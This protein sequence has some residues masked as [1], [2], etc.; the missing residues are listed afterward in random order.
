MSVSVILPAVQDGLCMQE[1]R[2]RLA[3]GRAGCV[4]DAARCTTV[5]DPAAG[6][7]RALRSACM[8]CTAFG[9]RFASVTSFT[10][11]CRLLC[12]H[13]AHVLKYESSLPL[14]IGPTCYK[15][16]AAIVH[17]TQSM[18]MHFFYRSY[19]TKRSGQVPEP[20]P[21]AGLLPSASAVAPAGRGALES[22]LAPP[23]EAAPPWPRP[24]ALPPPVALPLAV[25]VL[26][27]YA[28]LLP[29]PP[30]AAPSAVP[31]PAIAL[32]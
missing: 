22:V 3:V 8:P 17:K 24:P 1:G 21:A 2:A 23:P 32:S 27:A 29:E 26:D 25:C 5:R 4:A 6:L 10:A 18:L 11:A 20:P 30:L 7:C 31:D 13:D 28:R 14:Q 12:R 16:R 19:V 15:C 9:K